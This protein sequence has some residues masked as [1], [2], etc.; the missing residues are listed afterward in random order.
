VRNMRVSKLFGRTLRQVEAKGSSGLR[1]LARA[2]FLRWDPLSFLPLGAMVLDRLR[3]IWGNIIGPDVQKLYLPFGEALSPEEQA[4]RIASREVASYRELPLRLELEA[5]IGKSSPFYLPEGKA[6]LLLSFLPDEEM[7]QEEIS[8]LWAKVEELLRVC[9]LQSPPPAIGKGWDWIVPEPEGEERLVICPNCGYS[10]PSVWAQVHREPLPQEEPEPLREVATPGCTT[11][12]SLASFLGVPKSKTAKA[13][14]YTGEDGGI[15][16]AVIRGDMDVS[17]QKL[18]SAMGWVK[19]RPSTEGELLFAGIVPG[20]ASPIGVKGV[21][22]AV[23]SSLRTGQNFVAGANR[24]GYHL[25]GVNYP[26]DFQADFEGDL[27]LAK[28]GIQCPFCQSA[29]E[30]ASGFLVA[31][32]RVSG[33]E[34]SSAR[35][36]SFNTPQKKKANPWVVLL[37]LYPYKVMEA[38]AQVNSDEK[39]LIW[40]KAL[41]PFPIHLIA[42]G[43]EGLAEGEKLYSQLKGQGIEVLFDDRDESPGVKFTDADLIGLPWRVVVSKRSLSQGGIEVKSRAEAGSKII[44]PEDFLREFQSGNL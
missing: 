6:F 25:M 15:V 3:T 26:R 20:Y 38:V 32:L 33:P 31:S 21:K 44:P 12:E 17:E 29:F 24:E 43:E 27:A 23:D 14:F 35:G 41:A 18:S 30:S 28:A 4:L 10:A 37:A 11:I 1:L 19:L 34:S 42:L 13:V 7:A 39:G 36:L 2:G 8:G 5:E 22:V 9:R 16:F 40:P